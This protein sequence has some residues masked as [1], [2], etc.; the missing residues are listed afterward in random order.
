MGDEEEYPAVFAGLQAGDVLSLTA[1]TIGSNLIPLAVIAG[2]CLTP[3]LI[4]ELVLLLDQKAALD[5]VALHG[6]MAPYYTAVGTVTLLRFVLS[7]VA[8]GAVMFLTVEHLAGRKPRVGAAMSKVLSRVFVV[9]A[10]AFVEGLV[11]GVGFLLCVVP[12]VIFMCSYYVAVPAVVAERTGPI[13]ALYRSAEMTRGHRVQI[14][15]LVLVGFGVSMG[16]GLL[17]LTAEIPMAISP[18][19][20]AD[21]LSWAIR[22]AVEVV[23]TVVLAV[24]PAVT[25]ARLRGIRDGIDAE[26]LASVFA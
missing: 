1:R 25:Y 18:G 21:V 15:L 22:V 3:V 13:Q 24:L 8:Q 11:I 12:G 4:A 2:L 5:A 26:S 14:L 10:A 19:T 20:A 6:S 23:Q 9:I 16:L 7:L 17:S